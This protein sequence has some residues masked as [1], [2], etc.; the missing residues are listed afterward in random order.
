MY[1]AVPPEDRVAPGDG[2]PCSSSPPRP[3]PRDVVRRRGA[4]GAVSPGPMAGIGI[5][6]GCSSVRRSRLLSLGLRDCQ[7]PHSHPRLLPPFRPA[8]KPPSRVAPD[9]TLSLPVL[10]SPSMPLPLGT[11]D[12]RAPH[13]FAHSRSFSSLRPFPYPYNR[14]VTLGGQ[15]SVQQAIGDT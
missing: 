15:C 4:S 11:A 1:P 5:R 3:A 12:L 6:A 10:G 8:R 7:V 13:P 2:P 9:L 14:A